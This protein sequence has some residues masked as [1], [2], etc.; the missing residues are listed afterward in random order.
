QARREVATCLD[1]AQAMVELAPRALAPHLL[2][3]KPGFHRRIE[4]VPLGVV[5]D[6]AAWNYPLLIA[7]NVVVPALLAGN[8]VLVKHSAKT[9]LSGR[10][11][12]RAFGGIGPGGLVDDLVLTHARTS[13]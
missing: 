8:A 7:V 3:E 1:R 5:L 2:P 4:H 12:T 10:A 6:V 13:R 9:P 11:F